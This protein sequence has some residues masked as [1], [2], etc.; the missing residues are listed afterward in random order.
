[1]VANDAQTQAEKIPQFVAPFL[2]SYDIAALDLERD[3][4]RII[5]NVLNLGTK[6]ATDWL[7]A[8][9]PKEEIRKIV[10]ES[11][12]GEWSKKSLHY[13]RFVLGISTSLKT[14]RFS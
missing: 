12:Y 10:S 8:A 6:Q 13:W 2:W 5:I 4:K 9:Y 11:L 1:M 3:K 14:A 7:F